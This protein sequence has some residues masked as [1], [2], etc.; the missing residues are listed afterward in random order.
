M[1]RDNRVTV[2][3]AAMCQGNKLE[4]V[5]EEFPARF[6][7]T[8]ICEAHTVA[9]AAGQAKVGMRPIVDIYS[10]FLQRAYDHIFQEVALQNLPVVFMLDRGGLAGPD[11]PTH[12]GVFDFGYMRVFPNMVVMAPG[13]ERDLPAM[14]DWALKFDGPVAIRYPKASAVTLERPQTSIELG[15]SETLRHGADGC[16]VA[17]G[18]LV[19]RCLAAA[20]QLHDLGLDVGVINARFLKPLDAEAIVGAVRDLPWVVTLEEASLM[21]G[22]GSAVLEAAADAGVDASRVLRL[23]IP[24]RYIEHGERDELLTD[25]G[26]DAPGIVAACQRM[27]AGIHGHSQ[28]R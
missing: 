20:D 4:Q 1:R 17:C 8:G 7:D 26:M 13:D 27:A 24:D 5:R 11:G 22:F 18:A 6:F 14:L 2:L 19:D 10:T 9:F 25:L 16:L 12:H 23:G 28:V 21:G 3:T 15:R